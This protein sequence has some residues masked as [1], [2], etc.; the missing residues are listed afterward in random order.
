MPSRV[1][2][3]FRVHRVV[4]IRSPRGHGKRNAL[5]VLNLLGCAAL[6]ASLFAR[7]LVLLDVTPG[8]TF[9]GWDQAAVNAA[10]E[11]NKFIISLATLAF[12]AVA[13]LGGRARDT[14][15]ERLFVVG[16]TGPV[17]LLACAYFFAFQAY[18]ALVSQLATHI[19]ALT[20]GASDIVEALTREFFA[21]AG[22]VGSLALLLALDH[23]ASGRSAKGSS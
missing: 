14:R 1:R 9:S 8:A 16:L 10:I 17:L 15:S 7:P 21:F 22:A 20:P 11:A 12:G 6:L 4:R 19:I 13:Y 2:S 3:R 23:S 18:A 5:L